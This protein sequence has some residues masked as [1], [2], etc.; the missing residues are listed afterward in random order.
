MLYHHDTKCPHLIQKNAKRQRRRS[1]PP[2]T[3]AI[4]ETV[5]RYQPAQDAAS[6]NRPTV[7]PRD[8]PKPSQGAT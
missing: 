1:P 8:I 4:A 6:A 2:D 3:A 7:R 5:V